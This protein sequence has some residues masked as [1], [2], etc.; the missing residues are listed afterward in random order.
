[1]LVGIFTSPESAQPM[2]SHESIEVITSG[3]VGDRYA[4]GRGF[5]SGK[6]EWDAPITLI[7][8]EPFDELLTQHEITVAPQE[9]RRNL[10]TKNINVNWLVGQDFQ[11][12][13]TVVLH[14]RKLWPPCLHIVKLTGK[15]EVFTHLPKQ[16]GIGADVLVGGIIRV[17]DPIFALGKSK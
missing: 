15:G 9:L 10:V 11:I 17:G 3:L 1:M 8:Q 12:G 13:K 2:V 4:T 5:Y 7:Q 14:G 16:C 6:P